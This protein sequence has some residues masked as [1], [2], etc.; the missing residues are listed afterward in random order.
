MLYFKLLPVGAVTTIVPVGIGQ[1]GC[2]VTLAVGAAGVAGTGLIVTLVGV[3]M[4]PSD[5]LRTV[6]L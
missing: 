3:L 4:H 5:V 1:V 6:T 2:A